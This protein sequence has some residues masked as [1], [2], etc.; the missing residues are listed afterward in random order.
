VNEIAARNARNRRAGQRWQA[1]L[2]EGFRGLGYD[3][4]ELKL[5]GREDEGDLVIRERG[6]G[7]LTY[8]VIEAKAGAMKPAEFIREATVEGRHFAAHR[9]LPPEAVA[10]VA[11]V[12]RRGANW[13]DAYVLTT[14]RE[15]FDLDAA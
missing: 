7:P 9:D 14:V 11:V 6:T 10:A 4:E 5:A 1:E 3:I 8:I 2:R 13:K 15:F 12:K